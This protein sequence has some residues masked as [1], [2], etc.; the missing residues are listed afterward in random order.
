MG[1]WRAL[2]MMVL[3]AGILKRIHLDALIGIARAVE[4][5]E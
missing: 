3:D 2:V 4:A 1:S 5:V